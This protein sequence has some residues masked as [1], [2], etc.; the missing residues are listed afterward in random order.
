MSASRLRQQPGR[1]RQSLMHTWNE[2]F[3][4]L[5]NPAFFPLSFQ[6]I[7]LPPPPLPSKVENCFDLIG[8]MKCSLGGCTEYTAHTRRKGKNG[9]T[10][11]R[12]TVLRQNL[13]CELPGRCC[14]VLIG[15]C[16]EYFIYR[17]ILALYLEAYWPDSC[18]LEHTVFLTVPN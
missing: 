10:K 11:E 17:A 14:Y 2:S 16:I 9:E 7:S 3:R 18:N 8:N 6:A 5:S 4:H 1:S 15:I 13:R 12:E